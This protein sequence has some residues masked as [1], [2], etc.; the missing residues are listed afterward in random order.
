MFRRFI[1]G[2]AQD[3]NQIKL[4]INGETV[5]AVDPLYY[6]KELQAL[7][8]SQSHIACTNKFSVDSLGISQRSW[9]I[10][11]ENKHVFITARNPG[12][13]SGGDILHRE[14]IDQNEVFQ[15]FEMIEKSSSWIPH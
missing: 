15:Y 13:G 3:Y 8:M 7:K 4:T 2:T 9:Q 12:R 6:T 11:C 10:S 14:Y 1:W 5:P